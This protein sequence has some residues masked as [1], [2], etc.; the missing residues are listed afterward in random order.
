MDTDSKRQRLEQLACPTGKL[1]RGEQKLLGKLVWSLQQYQKEQ[2]VHFLGQHQ[3]H[4]ILWTYSADC[5]PL[6]VRVTRKRGHGAPGPS[7][8]RSGKAGQ[9]FYLQRAFAKWISPAGE[10]TIVPRVWVPIN[11]KFG[12]KSWHCYSAS[13]AHVP[14]LIEKHESIVVSFYVFDRGLAA[15]GNKLLQRHCEHHATQSDRQLGSGLLR[16]CRDWALQGSCVCHDVHNAFKWGVFTLFPGMDWSTELFAVTTSLRQCMDPIMC[17]L[18]RWLKM[19]LAF[20]PPVSDE[21][22][23]VQFW[24]SLGVE[25]PFLHHFED[26]QP[27]FDGKVLFVS[28]SYQDRRDEALEKLELMYLHCFHFRAHTDSRWATHGSACRVLMA[29]LALGLRSLFA[30]V[31]DSDAVSEFYSGGFKHLTTELAWYCLC[32]S[33]V[34][35]PTDAV[36]LSLMADDRVVLQQDELKEA[37]TSEQAWLCS[38]SG[39]IWQRLVTIVDYPVEGVD[40][41]NAVLHGVLVSWAYMVSKIFQSLDSLP[42]RLARGDMAENLRLLLLDPAVEEPIARKI[43]ALHRLGPHARTPV[44]V[45][46]VRFRKQKLKQ[47]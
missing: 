8:R 44:C 19:H 14:L 30:Y 17:A 15:L 11:M 36:L 4:A 2:L 12:K 24:S 28:E 18:P 16:E 41:R 47:D 45:F 39:D 9:E 7:V 27:F 38:L 26:L 23:E 37:F 1:S 20:R 43:C 5:T 34:A 31:V 42:W 21:N 22:M 25:A 3:N 10:V 29:S 35:Y 6:K 40:L 32:V 33:Y 46:F 13:L